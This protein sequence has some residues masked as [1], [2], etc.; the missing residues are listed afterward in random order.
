MIR[1]GFA[2]RFLFRDFTW[3][4][5]YGFSFLGGT[6]AL[7]LALF[8]ISYLN[9]KKLRELLPDIPVLALTA[10][11]TPE[12]V[13]DIQKQLRFKKQNVFQ[14]SFSR[15]NLAYIVVQE[16]DKYKEILKILCHIYLPVVFVRS[17]FLLLRRSWN[18]RPRSRIMR[19]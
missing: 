7:F 5:N 8:T 2:Q 16:Q 3:A 14:K 4:S 19:S 6:S 11:A 12:V 17:N 1:G 9:I 15:S 10:T 18:L 13:E